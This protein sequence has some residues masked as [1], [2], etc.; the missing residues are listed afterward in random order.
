MIADSFDGSPERDVVAERECLEI[1]SDRR[2][3]LYGEHTQQAL[4][5]RTGRWQLLDTGDALVVFQRVPEEARAQP[6]L[7]PGR[8]FLS[9]QLGELFTVPDLCSFFFSTQRTCWVVLI[10]GAVQ[11]TLVFRQGNLLA[12]QSTQVVD[13]LGEV[14][15]RYGH[16]DRATL[17]STLAQVSPQRKLGR[18]L[19]EQ[20]IL[21]AQELLRNIRRQMEDVFYG[22]LGL[23]EGCFHVVDSPVDG[24]PAKM[25]INTQGLILEGLKRLDED[26]QFR[27]L[28][29]HDE[30]R[31]DAVPGPDLTA[32]LPPESRHA[33]RLLREHGPLTLDQVCRATMLGP[34]QGLKAVHEAL[35]GG[36][37]LVRESSR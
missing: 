20:G 2:L 36:H 21:S 35:V 16:L 29:P 31:L 27:R 17:A 25:A 23:T 8:V 24:F 10:S 33:A 28:L 1:S 18:I 4:L 6:K 32:E 15:F 14:L 7:P 26:R 13:R 34:H 9:G 37:V 12:V 22:A 30:V 3:R 5:G 19:Q 11:R